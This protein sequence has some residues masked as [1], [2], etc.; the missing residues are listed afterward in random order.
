MS[1]QDKLAQC[2]YSVREA[3]KIVD[4]SFDGK[5]TPKPTFYIKY[6]PPASG[7]GGI[8][9]RVMAKDGVAADTL[10]TVEVDSVIEANAQYREERATTN[11]KTGLYFKYRRDADTISDQILNRALLERFNVAWET[12][13]NTIAW[14]VREIKR[15]Q[16]M[17]YRVT[18]VYP[19]V[20]AD[21]LVRRSIAREQITGQTPAPPEHIRA[22]ARKAIQNIE[23]LLRYIDC[24]YVYDNSGQK[25]KESV[26]VEL[27]NKWDWTPDDIS[28]PG[29]KQNITCD[30][31]RLTGIVRLFGDEFAKTLTQLCE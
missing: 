9:E 5:T 22:G 6:G 12:T 14:T 19:L 24:L 18:L 16:K 20:P 13:G 8:M 27:E 28:N 15:I 21:E 29:L 17:G 26:V 23:K 3:Q 25:G 30:C 4:A 10:V 1:V 7:K 31:S 2:L 11:D